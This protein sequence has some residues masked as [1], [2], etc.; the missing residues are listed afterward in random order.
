MKV[1]D[2]RDQA[3]DAEDEVLERGFLDHLAVEGCGCPLA[4]G[5]PRRQA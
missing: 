2:H 5:R 3:R 4:T 1:E